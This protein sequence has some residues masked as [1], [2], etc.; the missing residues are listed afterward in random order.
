LIGQVAVTG[1]KFDAIKTR[2]FCAL[3]RFA[4]ILDNARDFSDVNRAVRRRLEPTVR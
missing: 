2:G 4:I 3:G 1:V